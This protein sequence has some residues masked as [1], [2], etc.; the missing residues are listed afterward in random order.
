MSLNSWNIDSSHDAEWLGDKVAD[1][2]QHWQVQS[3]SLT[4]N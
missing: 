4:E 2:I 1:D 3:N